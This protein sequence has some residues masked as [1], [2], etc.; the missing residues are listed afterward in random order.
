MIPETS[1]Q[2][3]ASYF[4]LPYLERLFSRVLVSA[5]MGFSIAVSV[6]LIENPSSHLR[7]AGIFT[8]I[9]CADTI[10]HVLKGNRA[11]MSDTLRLLRQGKTV[12][13]NDYFPLASFSLLDKALGQAEFAQSAHT[14]MFLLRAM[15]W[16]K[17]IERGLV[18]LGVSPDD[19][20][21]DLEQT[22]STTKGTCAV[23]AV[24]GVPC[25]DQRVAEIEALAR[26][27][28]S[29]AGELGEETISPSALFAACIAVE[30][31]SLSAVFS[32]Y[33]LTEEDF[34]NAVVFGRL[35][36]GL[37]RRM[38][39]LRGA[40]QGN[41]Q[42]GS[43]VNRAWTSRPT[44]YLDGMSVDMT[45]RARRNEIGFL[46]G[47]EDEYQSM[48]NILSRP[49]R[50]NVIL[51]GDED[52]GKAAMVEHLALD[53]VR[54]NVPSKLFDKRLVA[55]DTTR[56]SA[57]A[58]SSGEVLDRFKRITE[59]VLA[60]G[61][62]VLYIPD[63][64]TIEQL[65]NKGEISVYE[66]LE[67]LAAASRIPVIGDTTPRLYR[68]I[69]ELNQKFVSLF[70]TVK[71]QELGKDETVRLLIYESYAFEAEWNVIISYPALRTTVDLAYQFMRQKPLPRASLDLLQE[72]LVEAHNLGNR[73]LTPEIVTS[74]VSRKTSIPIATAQG[75]EA[76][77]LLTL[78][79]DIHKELID[80]E[81]AVKAVAAALR[82]YRAGLARQKGPIASFLFVGPTGVGKTELS[83][84]LARLYFGSE[85]AMIRFDMSEYQE[86]KSIAQF[87]GSP[88]G[89]TPGALT[90][91]VKQ[92]PF[93]LILLDEFEK[94]HPQ[95]IDIFLPIFDE[96]RITDNLGQVIDFK[97]TIIICTSNANSQYIKE[98]I[99]QGRNVAQFTDELKHKL[100]ENFKPELL[101]RFDGIIAFRQLNPDEIG[102]VVRLNLASFAKQV[103]DMHGIVLQFSDEV[104]SHIARA[105]YDPVFGARPLRGVIS[106]TI[107]DP[108]A[109]QILETKAQRNDTIQISVQNDAIAFQKT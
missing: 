40:A 74:V 35:A 75:K 93:A 83:K 71:I 1:L 98:Q 3:N 52:I 108:L 49:N 8:L 104:V 69:I 64:H 32:K 78:E 67:D 18:R 76:E 14:C 47:H 7:A 33:H 34:R 46:V 105:G 30:K 28:F 95:S 25:E 6:V 42:A 22:V 37:G 89:T 16:E 36:K 73:A 103:L 41:I 94:A 26:N 80:Q 10:L 20:S 29:Q 44:S 21:K 68:Q 61:N 53:M 65:N 87:V 66:A 59:E 72:S 5:L 90:E 100:V 79:Q 70:D 106:S 2:F 85:N 39:R 107:K 86:Q 45:D 81:E 55:L 97:N 43:R 63:I 24:Q 60:A 9:I 101:N 27:A 11:I 84:V 91:S 82:Q 13:V 23:D 56:L 4:K 102:Q 109:R 96:G 50:N 99:E 48:V 62:I 51:V 92:H 15:L 54:D 17:E 31:K 12:L 77:R 38:R 58:S 19:F 57:G 88:D